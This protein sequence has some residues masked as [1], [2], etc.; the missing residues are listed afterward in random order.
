MV[1][2][3]L[4][5]LARAMEQERLAV[6]KAAG[7]CGVHFEPLLA[8]VQRPEIRRALLRRQADDLE[9]RADDMNRFALKQDAARR[10]AMTQAEQRAARAGLNQWIGLED[11]WCA[12][13]HEASSAEALTGRDEASQ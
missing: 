1:G 11:A 12:T 3:C 10:D 9:R 6:P 13:E 4:D 2:D 8:R 7:L 5:D